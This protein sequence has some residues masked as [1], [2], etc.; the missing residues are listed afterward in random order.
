MTEQYNNDPVTRPE[1]DTVPTFEAPKHDSATS[2]QPVGE[3]FAA[4]SESVGRAGE[5][6]AGEKFTPE[7]LGDLAIKFATETAYAAA[8][9]AN[10]LS[11]KAKEL[12]ES[13]RKQIAEKTPEGV[14]PNFRQ[15][16]DTMPDQ[17]KVFMDDVVKAY[18]D[19]AEKGRLTVADLQAQA[20]N[21]RTTK[22]AKDEG[23][24][25]F[26]LKDDAGASADA[27][28]VV[29]PDVTTDAYPGEAKDEFRA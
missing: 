7:K 9:V 1:G 14:D 15:F 13:Q 23:V 11:E 27:E 28:N 3:D 16:V 17:F 5:L 22:P 12:Y 21:A 20:Q 29:A 2:Q 10:T 26:D 4:S 19:M 6:P 25:A 18:H 24:S 8:G